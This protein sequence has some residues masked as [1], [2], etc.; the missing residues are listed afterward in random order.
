M[1]EVIATITDELGTRCVPTGLVGYC[2]ADLV[3]ELAG[4]TR[5]HPRHRF[6]IE[7]SYSE[8]YFNAF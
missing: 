4:L 6:S 1:Y 8:D 5:R 3:L 2:R 7:E